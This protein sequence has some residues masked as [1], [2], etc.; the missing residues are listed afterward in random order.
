ML[1]PLNLEN[2]PPPFLVPVGIE[3]LKGSLPGVKKPFCPGGG[4]LEFAGGMSEDA[5]LRELVLKNADISGV[6][7]KIFEV[8][9]TAP[10]ES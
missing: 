8:R 6:I 5:A 3:E 1:K 2:K 4:R 9:I 7:L 10:A